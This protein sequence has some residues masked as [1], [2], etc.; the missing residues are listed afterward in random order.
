MP[1]AVLGHPIGHTLSPVMHNASIKKLGMN[2][3]YLAFDVEPKRLMEVLHSMAGM[4]FRGVNLTVPLKEVAFKGLKQLDI[5]AQRLGSVNTI[6]FLADGSLKGYSTDGKGFLIAIKEAFGKTV[7][8]MRVLVLGSGGAGRAV[9]ITCAAEKAAEIIVTDVDVKRAK[10]VAA[11]IRNLVPGTKVKWLE[12][13]PAVWAG[14]CR[15]AD[16]INL[17]SNYFF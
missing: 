15:K 7:K 17:I 6:E 5:S 14:E 16:I 12:N 9:A 10:R 1:F 4:G 3:I 2:A 13:D 11:E 8:G